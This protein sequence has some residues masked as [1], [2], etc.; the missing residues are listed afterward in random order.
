MSSAGMILDY[1]KKAKI[2][3][4]EEA[5]FLQHMLVKGV[6]DHDN[7]RSPQIPGTTLFSHV[8]ANFTPTIY[9]SGA[10]EMERSF[11]EA[12]DFCLSHLTRLLGRHRYNRKCRAVVES[13][14]RKGKECL[15][16]DEAILGKSP[17]DDQKA[18]F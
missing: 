14:M 16:F 7:G 2:I 10:E 3:P 6:D 13:A 9:G 8:I 4:P 15:L 12:L 18:A 17:D 5:S 11:H 1:L